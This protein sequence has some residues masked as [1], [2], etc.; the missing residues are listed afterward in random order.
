MLV[1]LSMATFITFYIFYL[2]VCLCYARAKEKRAPASF[3]ATPQMV[4]IIIPT[5]NEA[6]VIRGKIE[7]LQMLGYPRERLE[8]IFVDGG[9]TDGTVDL[10][11]DLARSS[12]LS[13][14]II[15]EGR[16][17]GFNR[18]V[19]SGFAQTTGE[20]ICVTGAETEYDSNALNTMTTRL[21]D[22]Q[23]GAVTGRQEIRN[24]QDGYSPKLEASYRSLYDLVR[25]AESNIDSL[26][27]VKGEISA[28]RRSVFQH[29]VARED[30]VERGAIDTCISFQARMDGYKVRYD[31][32][33]VYYEL[34]PRSIRDS[35]RQQ[36]R[37]A[38]TLIEN[39][40]A[41]KDMLLNPRF[42]A[43]GLFI[44]PA[45]FLMLV[46]LPFVLLIGS[47]GLVLVGLIDPSNHFALGALTVG[48]LALLLSSRVQ[49]FIKTQLTLVIATI[50][51]AFSRIE[52]QKFARLSSARPQRQG[53]DRPG[54]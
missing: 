31:R 35:F 4:S 48:V 24:L 36:T 42:G 30:L 37:R 52:T 11:E 51:L 20:I 5:Y 2:A 27:D 32:N 53:R 40:M 54:D 46:V 50:G 16:R 6:D 3:V 25:R 7:N 1:I 43:F 22:P 15:Q 8:A 49:A 13:I 23:V 17:R 45:H 21:A 9:S 18:A 47:I 39:M 33:A 44:M 29:L 34:S 41:F 14:K 19:I 38:G 26:F 10:I 12:G 28:S